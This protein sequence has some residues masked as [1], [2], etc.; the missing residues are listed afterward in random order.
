MDFK[1]FI[2]FFSV[3]Q[4]AS[5]MLIKEVKPGYVDKEWKL[6][7]PWMSTA[8]L[9]DFGFPI[10][11]PH[12]VTDLFRIGNIVI[13]TFPT[14]VNPVHENTEYTKNMS[15]EMESACG[16]S[17][18]SFDK[19]D[20]V[21]LTLMEY[22]N[23][24]SN[25]VKSIRVD[26]LSVELYTHH[27]P[28]KAFEPLVQRAVTDLCEHFCHGIY[29]YK[30][31]AAGLDLPHECTLPKNCTF[32]AN[33]VDYPKFIA[34][35]EKFI[36]T[37][38]YLFLFDLRS[39]TCDFRLLSMLFMWRPTMILELD[40]KTASLFPKLTDNHYFIAHFIDTKKRLTSTRIIDVCR[41]FSS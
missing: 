32:N 40:N 8:L 25:I 22:V 14:E 15:M 36:K 5:C 2:C 28:M 9:P 4:L 41:I 39:K 33:E 38:K 37:L 17:K 16:S 12:L 18:S 23:V 31:V 11:A 34:E 3:L 6:N 10:R 24:T 13:R 1:S 20:I 26:P 27:V 35:T 21:M 29:K 19:T 7:T 30:Y